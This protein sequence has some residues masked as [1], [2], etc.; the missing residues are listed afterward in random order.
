MFFHAGTTDQ[1]TVIKLENNDSEMKL[2]S[3]NQSIEIAEDPLKLNTGKFIL[4]MNNSYFFD[5]SVETK[6]GI[7]SFS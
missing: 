6:I 1:T 2:E 4:I 3:D 5:N 7:Y